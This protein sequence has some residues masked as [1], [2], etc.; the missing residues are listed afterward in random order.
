MYNDFS[1]IKL[2]KRF[3][4]GIKEEDADYPFLTQYGSIELERSNTN[5]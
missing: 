2:I 3:Y 4:T 1:F 5:E